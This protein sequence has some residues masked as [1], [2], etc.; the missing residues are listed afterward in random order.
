MVDMINIT[1]LVNELLI[2]G[3]PV[4]SVRATGLPVA[5]YTRVLTAA[6]AVTAAAV[7]AAH[8]P[9]DRLDN[10]RIERDRR[11]TLSDW[12]QVVDSPLSEAT[13]LLW[14]A[15]RQQLRDLPT[16]ILD[17]GSP[18]WPIAPGG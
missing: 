18:I 3:L 2:A 13:R 9:D 17:L 16:N 8:D 10:I 14:Q 6:E 11:L 5:D 7:I 1:K 12:S 15:Y 4:C